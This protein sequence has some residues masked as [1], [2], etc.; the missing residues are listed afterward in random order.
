MTLFAPE[1]GTPR[2]VRC[3]ACPKTLTD[4]ASIARGY[5]P[6][7][8]KKR[9]LLPEPRRRGPS[10]RPRAGGSVDGQGDL[11]DEGEE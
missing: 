2:A 3:R 4:P 8:A 9:G 1:E 7:C 10:F 11:L 5:G 6:C